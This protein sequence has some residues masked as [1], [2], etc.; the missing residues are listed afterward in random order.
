LELKLISLSHGSWFSTIS[1]KPI[2]YFSVQSVVE[3]SFLQNCMNKK[4]KQTSQ[5]RDMHKKTD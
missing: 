4:E 2:F 3:M 5:F 1:G